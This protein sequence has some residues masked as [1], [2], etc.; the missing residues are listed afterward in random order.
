[1]NGVKICMC[2]R[3]GHIH[4]FEQRMRGVNLI[5]SNIKDIVYF[6]TLRIE[7]LVVKEVRRQHD[8][9]AVIALRKENSTFE[10]FR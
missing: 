6:A 2:G 10:N 8:V 5:V 7:T 3:G 4:R 9:G 1:M